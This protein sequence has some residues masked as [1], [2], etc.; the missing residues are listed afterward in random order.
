MAYLGDVE[1]QQQQHSAQPACCHEYV[2]H[3][4]AM[5]ERLNHPVAM[6]E[7]EKNFLLDFI[8]VII[9]ARDHDTPRLH[10]CAKS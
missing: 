1:Q 5:E 3:I 2:D 8:S 6:L 7:E 9:L 4:A 10:V